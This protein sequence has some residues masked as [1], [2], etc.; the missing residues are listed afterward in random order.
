M[1]RLGNMALIGMVLFIEKKH[2]RVFMAVVPIG[3]M[4]CSKMCD[5]K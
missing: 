1:I 4:V 2:F 3:Y 5:D